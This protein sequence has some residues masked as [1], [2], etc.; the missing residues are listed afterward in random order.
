MTFL[1][2]ILDRLIIMPIFWTL[3][4]FQKPIRAFFNLFTDER[5]HNTASHEDS[6]VFATGMWTQLV[7]QE[8]QG[9]GTHKV[10]ILI[11]S[12]TGKQVN[13]KTF[14]QFCIPGLQKVRVTSYDH[15]HTLTVYGVSSLLPEEIR[16]MY[17]PWD[18]D[19]E[20]I[21]IKLIPD[22]VAVTNAPRRVPTAEE[23]YKL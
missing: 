9:N 1:E 7:R 12:S 2:T 16:I 18:I 15:G 4:F 5:T 19:K 11:G 17:Q 13:V 6:D 20:T 8:S 21:F 14:G 10:Q 22:I 3:K 23:V